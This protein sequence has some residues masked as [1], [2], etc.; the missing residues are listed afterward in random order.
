MRAIIAL[1]ALMISMPV[2][3]E[4]TPLRLP[5][6]A[7]P[8]A[9]RVSDASMMAVTAMRTYDAWHDGDRKHAFL[10]MGCEAALTLGPIEVLKR[11]VHRTRPDGSDNNSLPSGHTGYAMAMGGWQWAVPVAALRQMA[12][13]H[14][15]T[16]TLVGAGIGW[17]ATRMCR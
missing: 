16:D 9:A 5:V 1:F 6:D 7:R 15:L 11:T 17:L 14:Y 10:E 8:V 2:A 4:P 12:W 3:A 13:K